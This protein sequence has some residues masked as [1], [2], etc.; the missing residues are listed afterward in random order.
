MQI[1]AKRHKLTYRPQPRH[2]VDPQWF[3]DAVL[4]VPDSTEIRR[5]IL[6]YLHDAPMAGHPG[7]DKT[8]QTVKRQYWWLGMNTWI[9]NY[10]K[11]CAPCQ[12]VLGKFGLKLIQT[13]F[14]PNPN[15]PF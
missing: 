6:N 13:W 3:K 8:I 12:L 11:G 2:P 7:R 4:V 10:M 1:W 9:E 5:D 15:H 14:K